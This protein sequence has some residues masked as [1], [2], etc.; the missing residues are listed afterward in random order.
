[1]TLLNLSINH[2]SIFF[3]PPLPPPQLV[4]LPQ[5]G[6]QR[7]MT[8]TPPQA[9]VALAGPFFLYVVFFSVANFNKLQSTSTRFGP[10]PTGWTDQ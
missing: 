9:R 3:I 10:P 8:P 2:R 5:E 1:M 6:R 4:Q 7:S